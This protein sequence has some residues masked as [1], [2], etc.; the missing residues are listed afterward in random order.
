MSLWTQRYNKY[1]TNLIFS[2][3]T[4]SYGSFFFS[5]QI[6]GLRASRLGHKS[7]RKKLGLITDSMDLEL[8]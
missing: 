3:H 4:V 6:Y 8:G 5:A 1:L 2:V 7:K